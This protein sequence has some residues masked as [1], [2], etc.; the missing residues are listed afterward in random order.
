MQ[1]AEQTRFKTIRREARNIDATL[2]IGY[3]IAAIMLTIGIYLGSMSP[4]TTPG[5]IASMIVLP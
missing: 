4:G 2:I 3:A 1:I 5:D